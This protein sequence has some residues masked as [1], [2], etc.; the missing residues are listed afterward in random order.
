MP[1]DPVKFEGTERKALKVKA[2]GL[3]ARHAPGAGSGSLGQDM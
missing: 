3:K 2:F 1:A